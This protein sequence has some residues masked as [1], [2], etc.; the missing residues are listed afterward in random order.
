VA[1]LARGDQF[2]DGAGHVLDRDVRIDAVLVQQIDRVAAQAAERGVHDGADVLRPA[3]QAAL[4]AGGRVDVES[5][6]GREHDL[7]AH[8]GEASPTSS[9]FS[10]GPYTS[11]VSN[12]VTPRSTAAR[13]RAIMSRRSGAWL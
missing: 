2:L 3:V 9:S 7:G 12:S 4:L 1:H 6:L 8:R 11:A 5:E 10:N 13:S